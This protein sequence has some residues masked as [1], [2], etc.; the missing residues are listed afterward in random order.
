MQYYYS[1]K[2]PDSLGIIRVHAENCANLPEVLGRIYLGIYPNGNLAVAS[3]REKLQLTK[4]RV[5]NCCT[6]QDLVS[7]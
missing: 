4:V 1:S 3:A 2:N 6:E 5:C 7:R